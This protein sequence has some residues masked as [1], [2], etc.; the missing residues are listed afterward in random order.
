MKINY[1]KFPTRIR[2]NFSMICAF[3]FQSFY[4]IRNYYMYYNF[5]GFCFT[6]T[7]TVSG[8]EEFIPIR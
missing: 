2:W 4:V 3:F 8:W 6:K 1:N 5:T 7:H